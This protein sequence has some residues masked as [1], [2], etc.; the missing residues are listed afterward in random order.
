[1]SRSPYGTADPTLEIRDLSISFPT[2][3]GAARVV[4]HV[5]LSIRPG[6]IVGVIGESG[7][8]KTLTALAVLGMLPRG[9]RIDSGRI[10]LGGDSLLDKTERER[11]AIRGDRVAYIPQDAL[12]SLNPTLRVGPQV[13]EPLTLH[14]STS[15]AVAKRKAVELLAAV[16]LRDPARRAEEYPHQF[17]GG[18]QQ[19]A[20][21]AMGLCLEPQLLIADEPTTALDVTVQA[22]VLR[23]VREI[24]TEHRTAILFITHDL[25][26]V[27]D[28]CDR[29]Y[30]MY[31]GAVVEEGPVDRIFER[32]SHPY[33]RGLLRATPAM[34]GPKE[35]LI[36]I[37]GQVPLATERPKGCRFIDRCA[38]AIESCQRPPPWVEVEPDHK[39]LCVRTDETGAAA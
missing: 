4:D 14:R 37:P 31:S 21:I 30:V 7:S 1:M 3:R 15:W 26:V 29:V 24:R 13:G 5:S 34:H 10:L 22:Q 17:S 35:A 18:M 39:A 23:L 19:R 6:E 32:P 27:A 8:G 25:G 33:T 11:R 20:M 9:A 12:R 16:H 28:L 38:F 36:P 2:P